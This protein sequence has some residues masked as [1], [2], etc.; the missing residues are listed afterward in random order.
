MAEYFQTKH[1]A[2]VPGSSSRPPSTRNSADLSQRPSH[3]DS[4][5]MLST[6]RTVRHAPILSSLT[7]RLVPAPAHRQASTASD[8]GISPGMASKMAGFKEGTPAKSAE[9]LTKQTLRAETPLAREL[10]DT[11]AWEATQYRKAAK[12]KAGPN[13][14]EPKAKKKLNKPKPKIDTKRIHV[15]SEKLC[16]ASL[17]ILTMS[18]PCHVT[19]R[20]SNPEAPAQT[21]FSITSPPRWSATLAAISSTSTPAPAFGV[22]SSATS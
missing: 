19:A 1:Q 20:Q 5:P 8:D 11:G 4:K 6:L 18:F 12:S 10:L 9:R 7:R 14:T 3:A 22:A 13:P 21:T 16:G 17:P 2:S 15:V